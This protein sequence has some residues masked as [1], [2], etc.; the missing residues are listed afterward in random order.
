MDFS[1]IHTNSSTN[2]HDTEEEEQK[3]FLSVITAFKHYR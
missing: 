3:N 2:N 1:D